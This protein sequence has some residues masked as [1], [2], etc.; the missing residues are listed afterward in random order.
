MKLQKDTIHGKW[1]DDACGTAF[2]LEVIGERWALLV[3]RELMLGPLRFSDLRAVLPGISAKVLA[4]RLAGLEQAG[5]LA[6]KTLP[7]PSGAQVYELTEWGYLAEPAIQ[8]LGRWAARSVLHDPLLP[9]SPVGLMMSMRTMLVKK[10]AKGVVADIG[11]DVGGQQFRARLAD[12]KL[13]I[14]REG[15]EGAQ[16]V[17]RA[18]V[19]PLI[20]GFIYARMPLEQ[21]PGLEITGD[22]G[23]ARHF[24]RLFELP[25]KIG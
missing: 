20:A 22:I 7:P 10:K 18:P 9:L 6:K 23:L 5:V 25:P 3:V 8:E 19:A 17:F 21:L 1:Y 12:R 2:A 11:F 13:P 4:E 15:V 24:A 16:A 14:V